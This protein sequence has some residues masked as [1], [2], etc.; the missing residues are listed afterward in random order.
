M[1]IGERLENKF[2]IM[3]KGAI[4]NDWVKKKMRRANLM[5]GK[6]MSQPFFYF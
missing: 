6:V 3:V 1:I 4:K 5:T 2:D